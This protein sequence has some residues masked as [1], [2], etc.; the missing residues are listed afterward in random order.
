MVDTRPMRCRDLAYE[1]TRLDVPETVSI[2]T[3]FH[4]GVT[5]NDLKVTLTSLIDNTPYDLYTEIIVL[6]DGTKDARVQ[7]E[8]AVFLSNPRFNKVKVYNSESYDGSSASRFKAAAVSTGSILIFVDASAAVNHGW[9]QPLIAKVIDE[10]NL[11]VVPHYDSLED[12]DQFVRVDNEPVTV[13]TWTMST[14]YAQSGV[15][16]DTEMIKTPVMRG[17]V[18]AVRRTFLDQIGGFDEHVRQRSGMAYHIELSMRVWM[19]GGSI[20]ISTCSRVAV[21]DSHRM[22]RVRDSQ[23]LRHFTSLWLEEFSSV[24]YRQTGVS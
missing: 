22:Q 16:Q 5:F 11:V 1:F 9:I 23:D 14:V 18:F 13:F 19:C 3:E 6:D 20:E 8:C 15:S 24:V 7:R 10:T 12:D 4:G 21:R 17:E 2:I